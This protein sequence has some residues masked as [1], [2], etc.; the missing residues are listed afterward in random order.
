MPA[1]DVASVLIRGEE[2]IANVPASVSELGHTI[3]EISPAPLDFV[4]AVCGE[5]LAGDMRL[6]FR[7]ET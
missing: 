1:G 4:G 6:R 7:K 5:I 3:L 2:P